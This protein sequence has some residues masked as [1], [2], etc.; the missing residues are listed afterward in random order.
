VIPANRRIPNPPEW[1]R[2]LNA[3]ALLPLPPD[4][5]RPPLTATCNDAL[6][7]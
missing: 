5:R 4:A 3:P 1:T 6:A 2:C 7:G